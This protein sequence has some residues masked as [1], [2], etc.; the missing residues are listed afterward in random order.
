MPGLTRSLTVTATMLVLALALAACGPRPG[1][2]PYEFYGAGES[3]IYGYVTDLYSCGLDG[4]EVT[5]AGSADTSRTNTSGQYRFRVRSG[6]RYTVHAR[7]EGFGLDSITV[8][9]GSE[10][11][12]RD[13]SIAPLPCTGDNCRPY[14]PPCRPEFLAR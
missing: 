14:K 5:L 9:V 2:D 1:F 8:D 12:R 13:F 7:A 11:I 6:E 10:P 3:A 4:A